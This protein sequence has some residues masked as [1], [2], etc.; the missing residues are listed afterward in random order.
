MYVFM[1]FALTADPWTELKFGPTPT[2]D[3]TR[4][5]GARDLHSE[6]AAR[7]GAAA[8]REWDRVLNAR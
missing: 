7:I 6:R 4:I 3:S 2:P 1:F 5:T 8:N